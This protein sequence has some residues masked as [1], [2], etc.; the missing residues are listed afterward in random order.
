MQSKEYEKVSAA[1]FAPVNRNAPVAMTGQELMS[2]ND[3]KATYLN[4][5]SAAAAAGDS[6]AKAAMEM[7]RQQQNR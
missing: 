7:L 1:L 2:L 4:Q 5:L 3:V 6:K